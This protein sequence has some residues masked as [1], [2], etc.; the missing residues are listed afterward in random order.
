MSATWSCCNEDKEED[1]ATCCQCKH[2]FHLT[3]LKSTHKRADPSDFLAPNWRCFLCMSAAPARCAVSANN[4][5]SRSKKRLALSSPP[6]ANSDPATTE[7]IR[8]IVS[9]IIE[10]E[11]VKMLAELKNTINS[12]VTSE[13]KTIKDEIQSM[14]ESMAFIGNDYDDIKKELTTYSALAKNLEAQNEDMKNT[15]S[16]LTGRLNSIEQHARSSNI[17]IQCVPEFKSENLVSVTKQLGSVIGHNVEENQILHCTRVA[18]L[19]RDSD[20]PRSIVVQFCSP[21]ARDG[22]LAAAI[23][24][25][26]K[27]GKEKLNSSH[28]GIAGEKKPIFITEHLSPS[29]KALHAAARVK[30]K[31][32]GY[33][34]VWVRGGRILMRKDSTSEYKVIKDKT[35]LEKLV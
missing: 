19:N 2:L 5:T 4:K 18:K 34:F 1:C 13:L 33:M 10:A 32:L 35:C 11:T 3:C 7:D 29:N 26:K 9:E 30:A 14:K 27:S 6:S 23:N 21:R 20:R 12:M 22:Y 25:N 31:A 28:L 24:Y 17:E 16:N 8:T 15:I